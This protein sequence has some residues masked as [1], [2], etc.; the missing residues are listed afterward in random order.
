MK[1]L[2]WLSILYMIYT[3]SF[4]QTG[5]KMKLVDDFCCI[6][7]QDTSAVDTTY[8]L[9]IIIKKNVDYIETLGDR[10]KS[11]SIRIW[12]K[13]YSVGRQSFVTLDYK[14][15]N[16]FSN[17]DE[18]RDWIIT[19][20]NNTNIYFTSKIWTHTL[21]DADTVLVTLSDSIY[22]ISAYSDASATD[23]VQIQGSTFT[24]G[25]VSSSNIVLPPG[26]EDYIEGHGILDSITIT[27]RS[28][29]KG[30]IQMEK[31]K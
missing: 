28:G 31:R 15:F 3:I 21:E 13:S 30:L 27:T 4:G 2:L 19:S 5:S 16:D 22:K 17:N 6:T 18:L 11:G 26:V 10:N 14:R 20:L 9:K 7:I 23:S 25:G 12:M 29:S 8:N 1:K 24:V